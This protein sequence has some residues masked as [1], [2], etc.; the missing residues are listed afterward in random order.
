VAITIF[1]THAPFGRAEALYLEAAAALTVLNNR[2]PTSH[3]LELE[4]LEPTGPLRVYQAAITRHFVLIRG[5]DARLDNVTDARL[6]VT[7]PD[8]RTQ[9]SHS[10]PVRGAKETMT[11]K[12]IAGGDE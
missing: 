11:S 1:D 4:D 5:G 7:P 9:P 3:R 8:P 6:A 2:L 12:Q 10:S